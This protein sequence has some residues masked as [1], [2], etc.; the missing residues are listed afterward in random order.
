MAQQDLQQ[1]VLLQIQIQELVEWILE[2]VLYMDV[3]MM[4]M[5]YQMN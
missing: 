4:V 5:V 3:I 1:L 2:Y